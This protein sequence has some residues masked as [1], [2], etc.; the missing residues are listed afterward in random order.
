MAFQRLVIVRGFFYFAG[1]L[2][3]ILLPCCIFINFSSRNTQYIIL[4]CSISLIYILYRSHNLKILCLTL[5]S[6]LFSLFLILD[7]HYFHIVYT[8]IESYYGTWV[9]SDGQFIVKVDVNAKTGDTKIASNVLER[10]PDSKYF[11]VHGYNFLYFYDK[12][13]NANTRLFLYLNGKLIYDPFFGRHEI[14]I[15]KTM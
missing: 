11:H 6:F 2:L 7:V 1:I 4:V 15:R 8:P 13:D 9:S 3:V 14:F 5:L 10:R 12:N